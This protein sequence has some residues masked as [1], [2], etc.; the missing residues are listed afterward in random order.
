[1]VIDAASV[2]VTREKRI[3]AAGGRRS[4]PSAAS[5]EHRSRR[6]CYVLPVDYRPPMTDPPDKLTPADPR[7]LADA[8]A[9]ALR[10]SGGKRVRD[11]DEVVAAIAARRIVEYLR[12]ALS[13]DETAFGRARR[14]A[15]TRG[16][17]IAR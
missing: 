13:R 9:F 2:P 3:A 6:S 14:P 15:R 8:I 5:V 16:A 10:Y 12:G 7:D 4:R 11:A 17:P 1:V